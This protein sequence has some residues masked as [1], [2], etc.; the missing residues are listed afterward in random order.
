MA[1]D[2]FKTNESMLER[3]KYFSPYEFK[4]GCKGKYC[5]GNPSPLDIDFVRMLTDLRE[6]FG[7]PVHITSGLRCKCYNCKLP[8]SVPK[9]K[10]LKG[11][12]ADIFIPGVSPFQI[13]QYW[14]KKKFGMCYY[15]TAN[16][17]NCAHVQKG[18]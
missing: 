14:K 7:K 6:H 1:K 18:W 17:G 5:K 3:F 9:S 4:C 15:G 11:C 16:M 13:C 12:A 2:Y 10:H 8:G